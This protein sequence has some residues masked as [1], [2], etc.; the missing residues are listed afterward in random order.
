MP[1][2]ILTQPTIAAGQSLSNVLNLSAANVG[3]L[4]ITCPA[5]WSSKAW[6]TFQISNDNT[7]FYDVY[8]Y[9]GA[10]LV[11]RVVP[12]AMI[13]VRQELW[14]MAYVKFRSGSPDNP[15]PQLEQR[16]FTCATE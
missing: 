13:I 15:V 1:L 4:R 16:I 12:N 8:D 14:R 7:T 2:T 11:S 10:L 5:D 6:L 9:T 3:L